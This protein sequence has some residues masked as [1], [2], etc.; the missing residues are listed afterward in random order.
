[1][2]AGRLATFFAVLLLAFGPVQAVEMVASRSVSAAWVVAVQETRTADVVLLGAGFEAGFRQG[3]VCKISRAGVGIAEVILVDLRPRAAAGLILQI[4]PGQ[5]I[6]S[7]D[8]A[9]V[10]TLKV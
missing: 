10:K 2:V 7:G 8:T 6:R 3:M 5:T 4:T 1:V 9:T